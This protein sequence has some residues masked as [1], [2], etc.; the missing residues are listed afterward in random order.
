[1]TSIAHPLSRRSQEREGWSARSRKVTRVLA[2]VLIAGAVTVLAGWSFDVEPLVSGGSR[3]LVTSPFTAITV[4]LLAAGVLARPGSVARR[5]CYAVPAAFGAFV[6]LHYAMGWSPEALAI[7][8]VDAASHGPSHL[9]RPS[10]AST[11]V[12]V[13]LALGGLLTEAGRRVAAQAVNGVGLLVALTAVLGHVYGVD[14]FYRIGDAH[15]MSAT[16][17]GLLLLAAGTLWL[18]VPQGVLQWIVF[19]SDSGASSQ[20]GLIPVAFVLIPGAA[21]GY[22]EALEAGL[23]DVAS[24][25]ALMATFTALV[26]VVVNYRTGRKAS[27]M[28]RERELLLDELHRVNGEL[29]DRVRTKV[30]QL[31]RQRTKLAL[32]EERD[33]IARDLH[34]RV[35]QRIFAAGLQSASLSRIARKE[36]AKRGEE[37]RISESLDSIATELDLAIRELRNS[38]FELTSMGDLDDIEQAVHDIAS[39]AARILGFSPRVTVTGQVAGLHA[40]LVAQLASVIQE[41]L[42]N[43]ARH[44]RASSVTVAVHGS[45]HDIEVRVTDDGIGLPDPLPRSSGVSNLINRARQLGGTATWGNGDPKGTVL[46]WCVPRSS[47]VVRLDEPVTGAVTRLSGRHD[48]GNGTPVAD[49]DIAQR[50]AAAAAS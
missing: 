30:H 34:D 37:P 47:Q 24:G 7:F 13:S 41:G 44:A 48:Q 36:A 25:T 22:V 14:G 38:I 35:I 40:D 2:G 50:E 5:V 4:A 43:V 27:C 33:R 19:G 26:I 49:S 29:E 17:A 16:S 23:L 11:L 42:S 31:N 1:M 45:D 21:W 32:F 28:D 20:R 18:T 9:T 10:Q 39:R 12:T 3:R 15:S 46:T 6:G 8:Q